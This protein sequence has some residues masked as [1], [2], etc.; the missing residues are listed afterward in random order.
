MYPIV[1]IP[2]ISGVYFSSIRKNSLAFSLPPVKLSY[3]V[4]AVF[5]AIFILVFSIRIYADYRKPVSSTVPT[6]AVDFI[7]KNKLPPPVLNYFDFG[8]YLIYR[9]WPDYDVF[10]DGRTQVYSPQFLEEYT[11]FQSRGPYNKDEIKNI[12]RKYKI[13]TIIWASDHPLSSEVFEKIYPILYK[14]KTAVVLKA[15]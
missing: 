8:G 14:D 10:I 7:I 1:S 5:A 3:A 6:E 12:V 2:T 4:S 9:L 15:E 11:T 13:K